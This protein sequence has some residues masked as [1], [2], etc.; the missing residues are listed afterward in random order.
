MIFRYTVF[1]NTGYE[2]L[3]VA[4]RLIIKCIVAFVVLVRYHLI[5]AIAV[6]LICAV[7]LHYRVIIRMF[8]V[9]IKT[10]NQISAICIIS[11]IR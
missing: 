9:D 11:H 8:V 3:L 6:I 7:P 5:T 2:V 4:Y 10:N 1:A